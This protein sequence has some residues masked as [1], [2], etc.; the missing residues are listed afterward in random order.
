MGQAIQVQITSSQRQ[1]WDNFTL[2]A[3]K[4]VE[5]AYWA[6]SSPAER[7]LLI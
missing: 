3:Y 2:I 7:L 6:L 5:G 4:H 1:T